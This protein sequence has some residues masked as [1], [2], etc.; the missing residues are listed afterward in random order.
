MSERDELEALL[1]RHLTERDCAQGCT[2]ACGYDDEDRGAHFADVILAAGYRKP[3]AI[4]TVEELDELPV[5]SVVEDAYAAICTLLDADPL[6]YRWMRVTTSVRGHAHR[7]SPYLPATVLY[8]PEEDE[9]LVVCR[10]LNCAPPSSAC[11]F[12]HRGQPAWPIREWDWLSKML[13]DPN[14]SIALE[15]ERLHA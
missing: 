10:G 2:L 13:R 9:P 7:H 15:P 3:R 14:E 4:T 12:R 1:D 8:T 5:G 11:G 6:P